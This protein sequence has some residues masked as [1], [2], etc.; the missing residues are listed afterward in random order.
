MAIAGAVAAAFAVFVSLNFV[1]FPVGDD[2]RA[3]F[4]V[5][6]ATKEQGIGALTWDNLAAQHWS[7]RIVA[8]RLFAALQTLI[9]G[10]VNLTAFLW[11]GLLMWIAA[12]FLLAR[13][14]G[15]LGLPT[16]GLVA[17]VIWFQPQSASNLLVAMQAV[18]NIGVILLAFAAFALRAQA[19]RSSFA[20]AWACAIFAWFT[21]GNGL[22][23]PV[24]LIAWDCAEKRWNKAAIGALLLCVA[25]WLYFRNFENPESQTYGFDLLQLA[26]NALIMSGSIFRFGTAPFLVAVAGG[27]V[28]GVCGLVA[29]WQRLKLR[30][31]FG[32]ACLLFIFGSIG[33]ASIARLGWGLE[34]MAQGRYKVYAVMLLCF[35][36][37]AAGRRLAGKP[38]ATALLLTV[39]GLFAAA[40]WWQYAPEVVNAGRTA[41]VS[42]MSYHLGQ[43]ALFAESDE[44]L[45]A[46]LQ[47]LEAAVVARVY[48]P[49]LSDGAATIGSR[50]GAQLPASETVCR[51][52]QGVSGFVVRI[53]GK[54]PGLHLLAVDRERVGMRLAV[55]PMQRAA[56]GALL[57]RGS[58][59]DHTDYLMPLS[60]AGRHTGGSMIFFAVEN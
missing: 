3:I 7:H 32:A 36:L 60:L 2:F 21:A 1:N 43:P 4:P 33:M 30:D 17:S 40:S 9:F 47:R 28:L 23:V 6:I 48:L 57:G 37:A 44:V 24:I 42:A 5:A 12:F 56:L 22:L 45:A 13:R 55:R 39:G 52:E 20:A 34:Y 58:Q 59:R 46:S 54:N 29:L 16:A 18:Q 49:P 11:A 38:L 31:F 27:L 10:W 8:V 35:A 14:E 19:V 50:R 26:G 53:R 25:G 15:W 41:S 51:Y